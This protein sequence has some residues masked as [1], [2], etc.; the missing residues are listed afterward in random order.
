LGSDWGQ[1]DDLPY[2]LQTRKGITM[3]NKEHVTELLINMVS[4]SAKQRYQAMRLFLL[5]N[6]QDYSEDEMKE[7][8]LPLDLKQTQQTEIGK[9]NFKKKVM[10]FPAYSKHFKG[11]GN[12]MFCKKPLMTSQ[13]QPGP[14][15]FQTI[16]GEWKV[17]HAEEKC[18]PQEFVHIMKAQLNKKSDSI[19]KT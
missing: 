17:W 12:C 8:L 2:F 1:V 13:E 18:F 7:L 16:K 3:I 6:H 14:A 19:N 5:Q 4:N 11:C 9:E 15:F 10:K